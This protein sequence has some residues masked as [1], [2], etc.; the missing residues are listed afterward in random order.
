MEAEA[1]HALQQARQQVFDLEA[2]IS[3]HEQ[4]LGTARQAVIDAVG[5]QLIAREC[6]YRSHLP[7]DDPFLLGAGQRVEQAVAGYRQAIAARERLGQAITQARQ[8]L[9]T[10]EQGI[11]EA[12]PDLVERL[13][14]LREEDPTHSIDAMHPRYFALQAQ[15]RA[16]VT[17]LEG[18]IAEV[19][20]AAGM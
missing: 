3:G 20:R 9:R 19:L 4:A 2:E 7:P 13:A 10:A 17:E 12:R 18:E 16:Q 8:E 5:A 6:D 11:H 15:W 1:E 14:L